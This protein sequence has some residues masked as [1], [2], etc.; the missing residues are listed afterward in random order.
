MICSL[1]AL[2][3]CSLDAGVSHAALPRLFCTMQC[4]CRSPPWGSLAADPGTWHSRILTGNKHAERGE[5]EG[6]QEQGRRLGHC[7]MGA[8]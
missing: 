1:I 5:D 8:M 2:L 3:D 7:F 6:V 4:D